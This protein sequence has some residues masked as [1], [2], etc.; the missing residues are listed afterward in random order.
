MLNRCRRPLSILGAALASLVFLPITT[1]PLLAQ[2]QSSNAKNS[3][4]WSITLAPYLLL[5]W[6]DGTTAVKG[7][8]VD[9]NAG[10]DDISLYVTSRVPDGH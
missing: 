7:Q 2:S 10:P 6:M 1:S 4:E 8:Q 9:V 5:P 3:D